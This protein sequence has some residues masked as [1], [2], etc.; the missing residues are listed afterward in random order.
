MAPLT[1]GKTIP[2]AHSAVP[3]K[4]G[5]V[6]NF[7]ESLKHYI[8]RIYGP[9]NVNPFIEANIEDRSSP[10]LL[11]KSTMSQVR[12]VLQLKGENPN[13]NLKQQFNGKIFKII[14]ADTVNSLR[15]R[16]IL[17]NGKGMQILKNH[18]VSSQIQGQKRQQNNSLLGGYTLERT[19]QTNKNL[20]GGTS[21]NYN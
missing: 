10:Q 14:E 15:P 7:N 5:D 19:P 6:I 18:N 13:D 9:N 16:S 20:F 1:P 17:T 2:Q 3:Q 11:K 8:N 12:K 21:I 4:T